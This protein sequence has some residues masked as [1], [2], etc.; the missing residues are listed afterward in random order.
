MDVVFDN[1]PLLWQGLQVTLQVTLL[2]SLL[3]VFVAFTAGLA[4]LSTHWIIRAPAAVFV[5]VFR[6]T[7]LI[8]QMFWFF[9][10]LP[11]F[12][13]EMTPLMAG[14]LALGLNEGAY[15]AEIVRG[16]ISSRP[17]GQTEACI[18]LGIP[19]AKRMRRILIPQS[20]PAM[21]PPFGNVLVDLLKNTSLV[22][23]V[24]VLDLTYQANLLRT[25]TGETTA[26]YLTLLVIYFALSLLLSW[27]IRWLERRFAIDR[28]TGSMK[29]G[30][31]RLLLGGVRA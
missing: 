21:L 31:K 6:G 8:V 4:R 3:M 28:K 10:A 5:E 26:I 25:N 13:V 20:I 16:T 2:A 1:I 17:K 22:S 12:G 19:P 14:V 11:L 24:T 30:R 18:A 9:F 27:L 23:F 7:S 29:G 15:A